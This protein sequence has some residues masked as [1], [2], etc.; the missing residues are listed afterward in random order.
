MIRNSGLQ[1]DSNA[2]EVFHHETRYAMKTDK[3]LPPVHTCSEPFHAEGNSKISSDVVYVFIRA[4][5]SRSLII[6]SDKGN[7]L[8]P[9]EACCVTEEGKSSSRKHAP[10]WFLSALR[11]SPSRSRQ[12]MQRKKPGPDGE[13]SAEKHISPQRN[14]IDLIRAD[15]ILFQSFST[16][17]SGLLVCVCL[18]NSSRK[19]ERNHITTCPRCVCVC[20]KPFCSCWKIKTMFF[21]FVFAV[22]VCRLSIVYPFSSASRARRSEN[23][24]KQF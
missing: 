3:L 19:K 5:F 18:R 14:R 4:S 24:L 9:I 23:I 16:F 13:A 7:F 15:A 6:K 8:L 2:V 11:R 22:A 17:F 10:W 20:A 1:S 12:S 21:A